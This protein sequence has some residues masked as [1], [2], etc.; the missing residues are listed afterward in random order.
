V[1]LKTHAVFS[2]AILIWLDFVL[3][4]VWSAWFLARDFLALRDFC[5]RDFWPCV[6]LCSRD[7]L[8]GT[9]K[10]CFYEHAV[11]R[12]LFVGITIEDLEKNKKTSGFFICYLTW[13]K[14]VLVAVVADC[15]SPKDELSRGG[16]STC[17]SRRVFR[18]PTN[19]KRTEW[20]S[21]FFFFLSFSP[22]TLKIFVHFFL[23]LTASS[24]NWD[25]R[26]GGFFVRLSI[27]PI[28]TSTLES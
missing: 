2:C 20:N 19:L 16:S 6:I 8:M 4:D 17:P 27:H 26:A 25:V 9:Q 7:N 12:I 23:F 1:I 10:L 3:R 14:F 21:G 15:W 24:A 28:E 13:K 11:R 22:V 18:P 5:S